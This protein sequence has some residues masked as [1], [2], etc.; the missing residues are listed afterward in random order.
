MG[1]ASSIAPGASSQVMEVVKNSAEVM[2]EAQ[3]LAAMGTV[4]QKPNF[5]FFDDEGYV[6]HAKEMTAGAIEI[7]EAVKLK[8]YETARKGAAGVK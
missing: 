2:H 1:N 8:N 7:I 4:I 6:A 3:I 5:E